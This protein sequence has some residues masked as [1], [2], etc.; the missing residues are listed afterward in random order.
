MQGSTKLTRFALQAHGGHDLLDRL[1]SEFVQTY[2]L[3]NIFQKSA[4]VQLFAVL[5]Y[6]GSSQSP[7]AIFFM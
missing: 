4:Y 1:A 6:V 7:D 3:R 2:R 5:Q